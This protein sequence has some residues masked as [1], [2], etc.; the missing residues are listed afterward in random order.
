MFKLMHW[1]DVAHCEEWAWRGGSE[2]KEC[3]GIQSMSRYKEREHLYEMKV[4]MIQG[5]TADMIVNTSGESA[6]EE[7]MCQHLQCTDDNT[8]TT[9]SST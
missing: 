6:V 3:S 5:W 1:G 9:L 7:W 2:V 4:K 8:S